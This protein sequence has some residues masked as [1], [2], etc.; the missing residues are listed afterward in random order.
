MAAHIHSFIC[1]II[2][3]YDLDNCGKDTF[4]FIRH[5]FPPE[6]NKNKE[7]DT[8]AFSSLFTIV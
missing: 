6:K 4:F 3:F 8:C 7:E 2:F 1:F 5:I